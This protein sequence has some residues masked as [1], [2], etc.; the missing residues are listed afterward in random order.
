MAKRFP[1]NLQISRIPE[2][3]LLWMSSSR[4][5][6]PLTVASFVGIG[7]GLV[8][9]AFIRTLEFSQKFFFTDIQGQLGFMGRYGIVLV[10]VIGRTVSRA[11]RDL[12]L[13]RGQGAR[14]AG[15][16]EGDCTEGR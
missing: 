16:N 3:I 12:C 13:P 8:V 14:C 2:Q 4:L 1:L 7:T 11:A 5:A 15:G 6:V 9:V 10:P